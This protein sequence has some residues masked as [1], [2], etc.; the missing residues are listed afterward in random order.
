M[1]KILEVLSSKQTLIER[2]LEIVT[3]KIRLAIEERS[4]CTIALAGGST[5]RPLYE[6]LSQQNLPWEQI[7][8][9][10]G[11][12]RY[13]AVTSPESNQRMAV[14]AW[15]SRVNFPAANLHPMP[16]GAGNPEVDAAQYEAELKRVF[17]VEWPQF[18][19]IL[20][21]MGDDGHTASLFPHTAALKVSDRLVTVGNKAD[22][23]RVTFTVPLINNARCVIFLIAGEDKQP[24]LE[25]ILA[26]SADDMT[27]P[28]RLIKPNGELWLLLDQAAGAKVYVTS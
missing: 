10:W 5:P 1:G 13:V 6:A 11:D 28:T 24:A 8:I 12:E 2:A 19:V 23:L 17:G 22:N 26:A 7:H 20:L 25:Q 9:F 14:E 27:Y 21:G 4:I 18:D 15:L 16:T 3:Q